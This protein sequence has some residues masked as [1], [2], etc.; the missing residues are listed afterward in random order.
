M[1]QKNKTILYIKIYMFVFL[2]WI[3]YFSNDVIIFIKF[4]DQN[5]I[6]G[7]KLNKR[8]YRLLAKY[9]RNKYSDVVRFKRQSPYN[10]KYEKKGETCSENVNE[11]KSKLVE[12]SL[13]NGGNNEQIRKS[14]T[15]DFSEAD[16]YF[17]KKTLNKKY[18]IRII[19]DIRN[20]DFMNLRMKSCH[21][22]KLN[23]ILLTFLLLAGIL[24]YVFEQK[25]IFL[26]YFKVLTEKC[27]DV[28]TVSIIF[29]SLLTLTVLP[30]FFYN[31]R[32][33]VKYN[34]LVHIK[35]KINKSN[36]DILTK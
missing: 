3:Y 27:W 20:A 17:D 32:K 5:Y 34:K 8:A 23:F 29:V 13:N 19:K 12:Y 21:K 9:E 24:I 35:S 6:F 10:E 2:S 4:L 14:K 30:A 7:S 16:S 18:Y 36:Y 22:R 33:S 31:L 11:R 25:Y 15:C 1:E 26:R 28:P